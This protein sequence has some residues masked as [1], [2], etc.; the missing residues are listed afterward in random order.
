MISFRNVTLSS[1]DSFDKTTFIFPLNKIEPEI[2][3]RVDYFGK[4]IEM[5]HLLPDILPL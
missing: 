2:E 1:V 5:S 4:S 3:V